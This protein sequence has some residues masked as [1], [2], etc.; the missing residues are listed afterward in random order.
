MGELTD[1]NVFFAS[2]GENTLMALA[3]SFAELP[4]I[5]QVVPVPAAGPD[6]LLL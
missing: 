2:L 5:W 1:N 3:E 4:F 6:P